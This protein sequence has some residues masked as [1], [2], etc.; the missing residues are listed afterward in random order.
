MFCSFNFCT[1]DNAQK[2][3][4]SLNFMYLMT[5]IAS[6]EINFYLNST[7][8]YDHSQLLLPLLFSITEKGQPPIENK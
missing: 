7:S 2:V 5:G 1:A 4:L 8:T 6:N 3:Q